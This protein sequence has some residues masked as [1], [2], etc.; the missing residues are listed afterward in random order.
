VSK[1]LEVRGSGIPRPHFQRRSTFDQQQQSAV[2]TR[3]EHG[4]E[5]RGDD[6]RDV[7]LQSAEHHTR[8]RRPV[9]R[10]RKGTSV[11]AVAALKAGKWALDVAERI[12]VP[13]ATAAIKAAIGVP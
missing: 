13:I 3:G 6:R 5:L 9:T 4:R 1:S 10:L 7:P 11:G 2:V 8:S 12:G